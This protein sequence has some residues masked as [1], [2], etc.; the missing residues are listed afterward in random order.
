MR[1]ASSF[2][3][4]A[5]AAAVLLLAIVRLDAIVSRETGPEI[6]MLDELCD[7]YDP[8]PFEHAA[9]AR[10]AEMSDGCR[11]C[12]HRDPAPGTEANESVH[13]D[14]RRGQDREMRIPDCKSCHPVNAAE[15][16]IRMPSLKGAYHRQCLN[17]HKAWTGANGC[18]ICHRP[19]RAGTEVAPTPDDIVGRMHPPIEPPKVTMY[20]AR[21][22]PAM[23]GSVM[24][25]HEEHVRRYGLK[26]VRCHRRDSCADCHGTDGHAHPR[27]P[28]A[29]ARSWRQAHGPCMACHRQQA[30]RHCH[31]P[32]GG[33]A[34]PPFDHERTGQVL[35]ADHASLPCS[36]CH[37]KL[38][39]HANPG[40]GSAECH[41]PGAAVAFPDHRP[42]PIIE[43][44]APT[45]VDG[46]SPAAKRPS[47]DRGGPRIAPDWYRRKLQVRETERDPGSSEPIVTSRSVVEAK[48]NGDRLLERDAARVGTRTVASSAAAPV[49]LAVPLRPDGRPTVAVESRHCATAGCHGAVREATV[50]HGPVAS[51]ACDVC[52]KLMDPARHTFELRRDKARLCTYCH[53]FDVGDRPVRHAPVMSGQCLGCH[54]PHG[55]R[56]HTLT[57][58]ASMS[59]LCGRCHESVM[60][61]RRSAH[62]PVREGRCVDCH[63]PHA[64]SYPA[65]LDV[66]GPALCLACHTGFDR[67]LGATRVVHG[68]VKEGC[69]T[70]HDAHGTDLAMVLREPVPDLCLG[71]HDKQKDEWRAARYPHAALDSESSCLT[72]HAPHGGGR[73]GLLADA[74]VVTCMKCHDEK[75]ELPG[76]RTVRA[77]SLL[78][79]PSAILHGPIREGRCEGCHRPHGGDRPMMLTEA[80]SSKLFL[81]FR[82]EKYQLCF[83]C[84]DRRLA[85]DEHTEGV[86]DF[87]NGDLNL[88][89]VHVARRRWDRGCPVCHDPHGSL[90]PRTVRSSF[91]FG[92]WRVGIRFDRTESGGRCSTGCHRTAVYDRL[93]PASD[94]FGRATRETSPA[95]RA[96]SPDRLQP[97][98]WTGTDLAGGDVQIP[99]PRRTSVLL[100]VRG[101]DRGTVEAAEAIRTAGPTDAEVGFLLIVSGKDALRCARELAS[102]NL[103]DARVIVDEEG[104]L[105]DRLEV[106]AW[107]TA[108]VVS[109][110]GFLLGRLGGAPPSLSLKL[111]AYLQGSGRAERIDDGLAGRSSRCLRE[112]L[113][114]LGDGKADQAAQL[115]SDALQREPDSVRIRIALVEALLAGG[116]SDEADRC[117]EGL[118]PGSLTEDRNALIRAR[119]L[120]ARGRSSEAMKLATTLVEEGTRSS[121]AHY[122]IGRIHEQEGRWRE[123]AEA[124]RAAHDRP[125]RRNLRDPQTPSK[126][127]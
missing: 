43:A 36:R 18:V 106:R 74:P 32:E 54:D 5:L 107:P 24:F 6:V 63:A 44:R 89:Y 9:H 77:M 4:L 97:G 126:Q 38:D 75:I 73:A 127:R 22:T 95:R 69:A 28:V 108:L 34:P 105:S 29:P 20:K 15:A 51:D 31:Y 117:F 45:L 112:A 96:R 79:E 82:A 70:C 53:E 14:R 72:C 7:L 91:P 116:R 125:R 92:Q 17:C 68:A 8:V 93:R 100:F 86:T 26:C 85:R 87:R 35:D 41:D 40:C 121:E 49:A 113:M 50:I 122:L 83:E 114:L 19:R 1:G 76:R 124:Y 110:D 102:R 78:N 62:T 27:K 80:Y 71:C 67:A 104:A 42:G 60:S 46:K 37:A 58:E 119:L 59:R 55:G 12:H 16:D 47:E 21:F 3:P 109:E 118:A 39:F 115:L 65:L 98:S 48:R 111:G 81:D 123:A 64:S 66:T 11:T 13:A 101:F 25:R 90:Q 23:G 120:H 103:P 99:D 52:H 2:R 56:D 33:T 94:P 30:C 84:H 61:N 57:R 10:M 88:H